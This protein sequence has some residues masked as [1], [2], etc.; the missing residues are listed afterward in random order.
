[1][2][3]LA[4]CTTAEPVEPLPTGPLVRIGTGPEPESRLLAAILAEL[5]AREGH[6]PEIVDRADGAAARQALELGDVDI[7]PGY[8]GQAWLEDLGL[9]NPPG[10]PR[11][12]FA[13]VSTVDGSRGIRWVR[14]RFDAQDVV[15]MRQAG[16]PADA[17]FGL[18]VRGIPSPDA[19]LFTITQ[20]A[21]RLAER[22]DARVCVDQEFA[23]RPDGW[24]ALAVAYS[25]APRPLTW[26]GPTEAV[27][28]VAAGECFVGLSAATDGEA[29]AA[30]LR[31]LADPLEVFP[32]FVVSVQVR[33]EAAQAIPRLLAS[34]Q[35]F[36]EELT[37]ALLGTWNAQVV[38]GAVVED[39]AADAAAL[40]RRRAGN[41][42]TVP[43]P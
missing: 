23:V 20:L 40:L 28:A 7:L 37:T 10:D 41:R 34:L 13:R 19:D 24:Q 27:Q 22:P 39:V 36:A 38:Q 12:S 2:V 8:T 43:A 15:D 25:I 35:P 14:P 6:R 29:W 3:L 33:D 4:G 21:T 17:T 42:G 5:V 9:P 1:M 11:T 30:G 16:P 18:F 31:L 32:A 26:V